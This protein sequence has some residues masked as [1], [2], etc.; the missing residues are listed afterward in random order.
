[1]RLSL[2]ILL[3]SFAGLSL[4][5]PQTL[6]KSPGPSTFVPTPVNTGTDLRGGL[7]KSSGPTTFVPTPVNTNVHF[8]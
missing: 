8:E 3:V 4:A 6:R 7:R 5:A 2:V 1:M